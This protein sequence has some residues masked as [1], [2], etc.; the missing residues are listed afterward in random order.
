MKIKLILAA[1]SNDP[2]KKNDPFMPLTFPILAGTAPEH[3][4]IF[5]DMLWNNE[6]NYNENVDLVGISYR[7]TA[8]KTAFEIADN[9]RKKGI[10]VAAGGPQP[11]SSPYEAAKHFD[12]VT[13]GE[14]EPLWKII[15]NDAQTENLKKFYVC[16]PNKFDPKGES[17]YQ[18]NEY[19]NLE[20]S[21][22]PVRTFFKQKY[23]FDTLIASR[24]C[25]MNCDF[26]SVPNMYGTKIRLKKIETV[27]AEIN[28]FKNYYYLLDDTVFG[29]PGIYNYYKNLYQEISKLKKTRFWTGQANLDAAQ[30]EEGREVIKL[31][32][33]SGLLYAAIGMESINPV[34]MEK[35]GFIKKLGVKNAG[36]AR[37]KMKESIKFIQDQGIVISGWFVVGY[38][39]DTAG[40]F[41]EILEFCD[42]TNIIPIIS[43]LEALPDTTLYKKLEKENR[44]STT[45]TINVIHPILTDDIIIAGLK[46]SNEIGFANKKIRKR[47]V[48]YMKHFEKDTD[49]MNQKISFTIH[50]TIFTHILQKKLKKGIV[51]FANTGE[52]V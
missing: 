6:I 31:A 25:P 40:S 33:K 18:I 7:I 30:S 9:F 5:V 20:N 26:C 41:D 11:T 45:K 39:E 52:F 47:T 32:A 29:R 34:I 15:L 23:D 28:T 42:E 21:S 17:Y 12:C 37:E 46:R 38:E 13:V 48:F 2:L 36:E 24:G 44:I 43:P 4:Y 49:D 22:L 50:K 14:G 19:F 3:E 27:L 16:S 8:E 35:S 10:K 51:G 1:S